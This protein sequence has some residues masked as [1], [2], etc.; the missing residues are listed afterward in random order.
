MKTLNTPTGQ[1]AGALLIVRRVA[2]SVM[3][4]V[5]PDWC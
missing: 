2:G 1:L 5:L 3:V 4:F